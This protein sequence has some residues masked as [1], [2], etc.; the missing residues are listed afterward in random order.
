MKPSIEKLKKF[1]KLEEERGYDD[2]A[3]MGG[4]EGI[5]DS[6]IADARA[7]GIGEDLIKVVSS[8][9]RDY[10]R[11]SKVSREEI[12]NGL[13]KRIS[14]EFDLDSLQKLPKHAS[15]PPKQRTKKQKTQVSKPE[16]V[17]PIPSS[18]SL[19]IVETPDDH[20]AALDAPVSV[21]QGI[22]P[23]YA[24]G[25]S[26][27]GVLTLSD[28]LYHF[29]RRY[30]DYSKLKTINRLRYGE[31]VTLIG[32]VQSS[33]T[34]KLQGGK[35]KLVEAI[36]SDGSGAIRATWFNQ[37]WIQQYLRSGSQVVLA[38]KIDQ[39]LGRLTLN[40][41]ELEQLDQENLH[42]NRIVPVYPLTSS[43]RQKK[44]RSIINQVVSYWAPRIKDYL[45][46]N[47]KTGENLMD[48]QSALLQIHFP[49]SMDSL[50]AA[51]TRLAFDE[52]FMLQLGV[53]E[54]KWAWQ[55]Q[56]ARIYQA[57]DYWIN[58]RLNNLPFS[59]TKAQKS[60]LGDILKDLSSGHPMNRLLQ[61]DVGSGKTIVA[62][63]AIAVVT[64]QKGQAALMAPTSILAEQHYKTITRTLSQSD[65][66]LM[67][68]QIRLLV[69][70]TPAAEKEE[71]INNLAN[72]SIKVI[73]GTHALIEE[74]I[75]F[76]NLQLAV[77]DE[78]HR[79]GV[80][81]RAALREKGKNPHILVMTATPIPRSLSL[82]IYGDLDIS[83]ID[84]MPPGRQEIVTRLLSPIQHE[85]A[86]RLI[87]REVGK[88]RQVYMVYPL[89]DESSLSDFKAAVKEHK[90]L[91]D[92]IFPNY[93]I[94]LLHGR[95]KPSE[96]EVIMARFRDGDYDILVTT[97][98]IEVGVDVPNATVMIIEGANRFGLAQLHQF[99]GRVGRG[100]D[101][102]YCILIP[103]NEDAIE[104]E[105]LKAIVE[106]NDG[107]VLA[108]KDLEQRG[109]GEFLGTRQSG[110]TNLRLASITD[111]KL[112]QKARRQALKL[113]ESD[114][115]F[116]SPEHQL[117]RKAMRKF[118]G[119]N[120][121]YGEIS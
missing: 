25:L 58:E 42:T 116:Q 112:I 62:A 59:L 104:N 80:E 88:G 32:T 77:I 66:V 37:P 79:F 95:L 14:Q 55:N 99:R 75:H 50:E 78:Q 47:I 91:Q 70:A 57:E 81:Q 92:E 118:W 21:L 10:Q 11:L 6:W 121:N 69:G 36:I 43:I 39:Y 113:F 93:R 1:F 40:N 64:S 35:L 110:Y 101:K 48:L 111:T 114:P 52:I 84:E 38:G 82:T 29:P 72:G 97:S 44:L 83:I 23:K 9:L 49:D 46:E 107:F 100:E 63:L 74:P 94:G 31:Q 60:A 24:K 117:L 120:Y 56:I 86:Y 27:I 34:R 108:E 115:K 71:I 87:Q 41:P 98:V 109:P 5:L 67:P 90:R 22:G 89:I 33:Q 103:Q 26:K 105:R 4:L 45:P 85:I 20:L 13:W 19:L 65:A 8:R 28:L 51:R 54:Q 2:K 15:E 53:L 76:Q 17:K 16:I 12:L 102:S 3:V 18:S 7:D 61:G 96:K 73:I 119:E 68:N 30:D 106:T